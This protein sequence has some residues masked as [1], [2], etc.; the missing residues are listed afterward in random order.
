[1]AYNCSYGISCKYPGPPS[2]LVQKWISILNCFRLGAANVR[3]SH[4]ARRRLGFPSVHFSSLATV[5]GQPSAQGQKAHV[6]DCT[7]TEL[8]FPNLPIWEILW[9]TTRT[10]HPSTTAMP[11][12]YPVEDILGHARAG[13]KMASLYDGLHKTEAPFLVV[14]SLA[15]PATTYPDLP[16]AFKACSLHHTQSTCDLRHMPQLVGRSG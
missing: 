13:A 14:G 11:S 5:A 9:V 3:R 12:D 15:P 10:P 7:D 2:R 1:M 16:K 4:S 8:Q 6:E